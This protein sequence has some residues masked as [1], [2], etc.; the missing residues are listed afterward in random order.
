[1]HQAT[2]ND[3]RVGREAHEFPHRDVD[4]RRRMNVA[5]TSL[6]RSD[7]QSGSTMRPLLM[8][9]GPMRLREWLF[10]RFYS[11]RAHMQAELF[12]AA[13]LALVPG[14]TLDLVPTDVAHQAMAWMG[15]YERA[16]SLQ[17]LELARK[18]GLLVDVGANY[19]YYTC[20][21]AAT[22]A[23]NR[24]VAFEASPRNIVGLT[25]NV[26][27]NRLTERV[28]IEG[29]AVGREEGI[30]NFEVG[31]E[32]QT[33][34]GGLTASA[35]GVSVPV[36]SLDAYCR[37]KRISL[38]NVLKVDV[39]GADT[40]V[41]EGASELLR[42]HRILNVF[43]EENPGR[44]EQLGISPDRPAALLRDL[45]YRVQQVARGEFMASLPA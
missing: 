33:G 6:A 40:W 20:L 23:A 34:W 4:V 19:G 28:T 13:P 1:M 25:H 21:W 32:G 36:V 2:G 37:E 12:K 29:C 39:E 3:N 27:Q 8:R 41:L 35:T 30:M 38:I 7:N 11:R 43:F 5:P 31:P 26:A 15:F 9:Y 10:Y 14:V 24:V 22:S 17:M 18:G 44:M 42:E 16:S 45:G